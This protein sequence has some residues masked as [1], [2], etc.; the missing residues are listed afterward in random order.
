MVLLSHQVGHSCKTGDVRRCCWIVSLSVRPMDRRVERTACS[1]SRLDTADKGAL[2]DS[3]EYATGRAGQGRAG[4]GRAG[5]GRA[6]QGRAGVTGHCMYAPCGEGPIYSW[7][8]S[9]PNLAVNRHGCAQQPGTATLLSSFCPLQPL[10]WPGF[11][12]RLLAA[13]PC[14]CGIIEPQHKHMTVLPTC[15][16]QTQAQAT[17]MCS[18]GKLQVR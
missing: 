10:S 11:A 2:C 4:Q 14:G 17:C 13:A 12:P 1:V 18:I 8:T 7:L 15:T 6:G 3:M 16:R 5:Q 9:Y